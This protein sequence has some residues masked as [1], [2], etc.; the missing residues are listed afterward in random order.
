MSANQTQFIGIH[1]NSCEKADVESDPQNCRIVVLS[2][3]SGSGKTTVVE[4]LIEAAP[5]KLVKSVSATTRPPRTGEVDG[6][7]YY[8]LSRDQFL[9]QLNRGDFV[10]HA[11]VFQS[12]HLYGT[13]KSEIERAAAREAWAFLEIDVEG[14]MQV[15]DQY[16]QTVSIFLKTPSPSVFEQ[17]LK[18]RG[19]ESAEVIQRRLQTAEKELQSADRYRFQVINDDLEQTIQQ[20]SEI[21]L[22][23]EKRLD[24]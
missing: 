20:I 5:V 24:A 17:R 23:Q 19:T 14:T 18:D 2:G 15:L 9:T 11:E 21:L 1:R 16:P 6:E 7:A 4:R 10:E 3:P 13:L 22:S 8:F 12:G